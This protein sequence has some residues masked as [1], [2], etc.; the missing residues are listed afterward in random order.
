MKLSL[1][2]F[3]HRTHRHKQQAYQHDTIG[4]LEIQQNTLT[5][6]NHYKT[7]QN[8]TGDSTTQRVPFWLLMLPKK[9][10]K[11]TPP[12]AGPPE[13][14]GRSKVGVHIADVTHFLRPETV[15]WTSKKKNV[16]PRVC[17]I[18]SRLLVAAN[19]RRATKATFELVGFSNLLGKQKSKLLA[20][21]RSFRNMFFHQ[22]RQGV[23]SRLV[24]YTQ[25][26]TKKLSQDKFETCNEKHCLRVTFLDLISILSNTCILKKTQGK[27]VGTKL[28]ASHSS[29]QELF[30][31]T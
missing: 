27:K 5:T 10:P 30:G 19:R 17:V 11:N 21:G 4:R 28:I 31:T 23:L 2:H 13:T 16:W 20:K 3:F 18:F 22:E 24:Y 14:P 25:Q 26:T 6:T 8:K 15:T 29:P 9:P 12:F 7:K 1:K